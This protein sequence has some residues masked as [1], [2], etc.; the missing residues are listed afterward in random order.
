[1]KTSATVRVDGFGNLFV[2]HREGVFE[3]GRGKFYDDGLVRDTVYLS[4]LEPCPH[5]YVHADGV[6]WVCIRCDDVTRN[7]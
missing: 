1:M 2:Y 3:D 7:P 6:S 5:Q 4:D